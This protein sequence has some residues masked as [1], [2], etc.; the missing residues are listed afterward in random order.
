MS[1]ICVSDNSEHTCLTD[2]D[3][4]SEIFLDDYKFKSELF[5]GPM[6]SIVSP[7]EELLKDSDPLVED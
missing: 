1:E 3:E 4:N 5:G 7:I 2:D 6:S